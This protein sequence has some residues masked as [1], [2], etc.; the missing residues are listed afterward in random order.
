MSAKKSIFRITEWICSGLLFVSA[1][2]MILDQAKHPLNPSQQLATDTVVIVRV[3]TV[4]ID[5]PVYIDREIVRP[6]LVQVHDTLRI[7]DTLFAQLP[8]E[9]L[10][11]RDSLYEAWVSGIR[12]ALDSIRIFAPVQ[13]VTITQR[14]K[15]P[16]WGIGITAGYGVTVVDK[17]VRLTP[18]I[19]VGISYN[20][21]QW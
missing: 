6:A 7:H 13:T 19:G 1:A 5:R 9:Q 14:T 20:I 21:L 18:F 4:T 3:D 15:P 2:Y 16:N 11:Y 8:V 12:P 17:N 10:R